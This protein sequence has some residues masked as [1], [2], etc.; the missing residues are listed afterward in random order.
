MVQ[1]F[2]LIFPLSVQGFRA[3]TDRGLN[4]IWESVKLI[5][6]I[7]CPGETIEEIFILLISLYIHNLFAW[8]SSARNPGNRTQGHF[9]IQLIG[10]SSRQQSPYWSKSLI[11][12]SDWSLGIIRFSDWSEVEAGLRSGIM[13]TISHDNPPALPQ[14]WPSVT[15][16]STLNK[17]QQQTWERV[18]MQRQ[19]LVKTRLGVQ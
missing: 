15:I 8:Y 17:W 10:Q 19:L 6:D 7:L 14:P 2:K 3:L 13:V 1:Q 18:K 4:I 16:V 11:Q 9:I 12:A 5:G